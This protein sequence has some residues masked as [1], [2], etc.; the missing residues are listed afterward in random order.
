MFRVN[1]ISEGIRMC[2]VVNKIYEENTEEREAYKIF[3]DAPDG[4]VMS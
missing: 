2:L 1:Q 4:L 3:I